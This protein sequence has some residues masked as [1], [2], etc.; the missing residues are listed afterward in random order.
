MDGTVIIGTELNTKSFDAQ[1]RYLER[2][3]NDLESDFYDT[4]LETKKI[5]HCWI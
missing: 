1:I 2:K 5:K 4:D 3:L